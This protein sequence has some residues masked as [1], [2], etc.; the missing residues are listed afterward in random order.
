MN[1]ALMTTLSAA[2]LSLSGISLSHAES[3]AVEGGSIFIVDNSVPGSQILVKNLANAAAHSCL[4][5]AGTN[6]LGLGT[7]TTATDIVI[8][9]GTAVITTYNATLSA[10]DIKLVDVAS[11]PITSV[12][13]LSECYATVNDGKLTI[14]CLQYDDD[15]ISVVLGQRGKSM[16]FEFES[17]KPGK[18]HG[19][20]HG[21]D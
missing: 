19:H 18:G 3:V 14:P 17:Y 21:H 6:L 8:K 10:T 9:N 11:C 4:V 16:N 20:G 5:N 2:L 7:D 12:A 13:D 1:K 15:V